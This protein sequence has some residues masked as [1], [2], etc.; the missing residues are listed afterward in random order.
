MTRPNTTTALP[1]V[2]AEVLPP[3]AFAVEDAMSANWVVRKV[4]E[5][6]AYAKHVKA[7]ADGEVRRAENEEKFFVHHYGRQLEEWARV[8]IVGGRRKCVKLPAG[9]VGFR[10]DPPKLDVADEQRLIGWCRSALPEALRV[11]TRI[12]KS[13]VKGH[14]QQ[15]GECPDGAS[16]SGGGQRF[17][18]R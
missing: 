6:R 4:A 12:L 1:A 11:E 5:A 7:W 8:E 9:T 18:I 10:R 15:T 17:Y 13:L 3:E 2:L 16:M 14:V